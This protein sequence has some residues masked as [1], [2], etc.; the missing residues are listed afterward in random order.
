MIAASRFGAAN[1]PSLN[2]I[3]GA[4]TG[5]IVRSD[6]AP[7]GSECL[8]TPRYPHCLERAGDYGARKRT[9][10][11]GNLCCF[12]CPPEVIFLAAPRTSVCATRHWTR[13]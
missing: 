6:R 13:R 12:R 1:S 4:P 2:A 8:D 5:S 11:R 10:N 7:S 3:A 9:A